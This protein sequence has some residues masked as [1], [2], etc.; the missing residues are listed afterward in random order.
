MCS[1]INRRVF[2]K[3]T[4]VGG[5]GMIILKNSR[6]TLSNKEAEK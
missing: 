4:V 3:T 2:L 6:N 5:L 1:G